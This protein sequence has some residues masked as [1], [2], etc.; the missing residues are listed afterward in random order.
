[1][2]TSDTDLDKYIYKWN[3]KREQKKGRFVIYLKS[4]IEGKRNPNRSEAIQKVALFSL[5]LLGGIL[6]LTFPTS[7]GT[8]LS[9][10]LFSF[11]KFIFV[12][13]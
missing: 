3:E 10:S 12:M 7:S 1:M 13:V 8:P 5:V 4:E 6:F 2:N 9:L 11:F